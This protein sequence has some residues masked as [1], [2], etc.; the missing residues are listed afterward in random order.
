MGV[1]PRKTGH[2]RS[3]NAVNIAFAET[4]DPTGWSDRQADHGY[5]PATGERERPLPLCTLD[6][7]IPTL[8]QTAGG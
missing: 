8:L 4:R 7:G 3:E 5:G 1:F 6:S 2:F